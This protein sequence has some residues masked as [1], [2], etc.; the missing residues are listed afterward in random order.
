MRLF[1]NIPNAARNPYCYPTVWC[2]IGLP[3]C[4][5]DVKSKKAYLLFRAAIVSSA[6]R[7]SL[8]K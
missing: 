8:G 3:R 6:S 1:N 7:V 4:A 5:R 2:E